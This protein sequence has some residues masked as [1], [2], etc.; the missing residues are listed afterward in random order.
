MTHESVPGL[1]VDLSLELESS[2]RAINRLP[3]SPSNPPLPGTENLV[4]AT[5]TKRN[6]PSIPPELIDE[7]IDYLWDDKDAL[8]DC[9][10]V[11]RLFYLRT[12]VHLFHS[13]ELNRRFIFE[14][15]LQNILPYIKKITIRLN[16][17]IPG[18]T[19]FLSSL[20]NLT[21]L[22]LD[23]LKFPDPW[24]LH[25]LVCQL[26][27][28]TSLDLSDV[29]W[30]N[31][32]APVEPTT[33]RNLDA[34]F[35]R[36]N[37]ISIY[38]TS[39]HASVVE[40]LIHRRELQAIYVDSLNELCIKWP[41]GEYLSSI[42]AF[43]RAASRTLKS[44]DIRIRRV[45]SSIN[46]IS[47][48][49]A[50][51]DLLPLTMPTLQIEMECRRHGWQTC[52]MTWLVDSLRNGAN[53]P[54]MVETLTLVVVPPGLYDGMEVRLEDWEMQFSMLDEILTSPVMKVFQQLKVTLKPHVDCLPSW[55][56]PRFIQWIHEILARVDKRNM[57]VVDVVEDTS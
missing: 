48:W 57:L 22:H 38:E 12:R 34:P 50:Q 4:Q 31:R 53:G 54:I 19:P 26:R 16:S 18:L 56:A 52:A 45:K 35:P 37:N 20:P 2:N 6:F 1:G 3:M 7:I 46:V 51:P 30:I 33:T 13:I 28:L 27:G 21:A 39:F 15:D 42:C 55:E 17:N 44:L 32:D 5:A 9:S 40:L 47:S 23:R 49:P 25:H 11:C 29:R 8:F 43:V 10:F 41:P 24:S 36:I 14:P